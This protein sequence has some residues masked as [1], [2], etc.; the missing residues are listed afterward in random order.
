MR[1]LGFWC[2]C[3][4]LFIGCGA[5]R[6]EP[7]AA[8]VEEPPPPPPQPQAEPRIWENEPSYTIGWPINVRMGILNTGETVV[9]APNGESYGIALR[10]R[11]ADA[12]PVAPEPTESGEATP[13]AEAAPPTEGV[14]TPVPAEGAEGSG[15][16]ANPEAAEATPTVEQPA[17]ETPAEAPPA[18]PEIPMIDCDSIPASSPEGGL[19]PLATGSSAYRRVDIARQCPLNEPGR[20]LVEITLEIPEVEGGDVSG[21][22]TP[23]TLSVE[24]T[25]PDPPVSARVA[26]QDTY[27]LGQPI[28][29]TVSFTNFGEER[30]NV[31][32]NRG[33]MVHLAAE[34]NGESVPCS[35][36]RRGR[37]GR[38]RL[39]TGESQERTV[40]LA[41]R[42][43][44]T[45]PGTYTITPR[46]ELP[47]AGARSVNGTFEVAPFT[48]EIV[49]AE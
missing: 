6:N 13:P 20:Y 27:T 21:V 39:A 25:L 26:A 38:G 19:F 32:T 41:D 44:L 43:Q 8:P 31:I 37:G 4:F 7:V 23:V 16:P 45:I 11:R 40:D 36:P 33:M 9:N 35:D 17:E 18:P 10:A 46:V 15:A 2:L 12:T 24:I 47:R 28:E 48:F 14:E 34:S 49:A 5:T 42:C 1:W 30:I 29:V 3:G 22:Q